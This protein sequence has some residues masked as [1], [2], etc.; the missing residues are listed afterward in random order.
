M[1]TKIDVKYVDELVK[2][3]LPDQHD[4]VTQAVEYSLFSGGKRSRPIL[5]LATARAVCGR[6]TH[7]A[8]I[9]ATALEYIH[10]YSL[11]HDDLPAMDNDDIRRGK[12]S[13]HMQFGE[14]SAV[15][16]GDALLNLACEAV[17]SGNFAENG[18]AEAC[19]TLF[20]MSG[21][22][23]MIYGQS[24]DLFTET[25]SIED[26]DAVALHKTGD[27]I[28]AA[29][30][31]G[32]LTGGATKAEIPVF[33]QIGQKFGIAYQVIDDMLDADKIERS[34]LDVLTERECHEYAERL[35]DEIKALCDSLTKYDLSF[36][37]DY[38]D[39]NLSRNK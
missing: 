10:T 34:Y 33:D 39:K 17:F 27:L 23:G 31:C 37:K 6:I 19:K 20:K 25:R 12:R 29:L 9:M 14:A 8:K 38:A 5:L 3:F 35:T 1:A 32:A 15:L 11:I 7:N 28:R 21:I 26:A 36:I 4:K 18:Y 24:L 13:C 2:A 22:T 30:V 16:A